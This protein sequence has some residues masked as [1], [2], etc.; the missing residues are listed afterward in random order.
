MIEWI[1]TTTILE[2]L[3]DYAN[4]DA[5]SRLSARFRRPIVSF[6]RRMG[7]SPSDADDVA[8]ETL[9]TFAERFRK[10]AF[11]P[12][13]GRLSRWLFGIAYRQ[14]LGMRRRA[15]RSPVPVGD[16]EFDESFWA[17]VPQDDPD[18]MVWD[19]EWERAVLDECLQ[20][21]RHEAEAIT[22][23]AFELVVLEG[24]TSEQA[25]DELGVPIKTVYNAKHRLLKRI[26]ELRAE[27]EEISPG[28][29]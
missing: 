11:D 16:Q 1:T 15:A 28:T 14:A 26:R 27:L 8:Q 13:K 9:L 29:C 4:E 3:Q 22:V 19:E 5:W 17:N 25:A 7:L 12:A 24:R 18:S 6:A 21:I 23:R 10:G 2:R 20:R